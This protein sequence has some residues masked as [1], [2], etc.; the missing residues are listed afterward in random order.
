MKKFTIITILTIIL[1]S[2]TVEKIRIACVGDS[3]TEG[4]GI[5]F[6]NKYSYPAILNSLLGP[7]YRVLNSGKGG[8]TL[9]KQGDYSYWNAKEFSNVFAFNPDI[10]IIKLGTNDTK[11]QNWNSKRFEADYQALIDTLKS[12]P[13]APQIIMCI[14]VPVFATQWGINDSTLNAGVI[15]IIKQIAEKNKIQLVDLN[16]PLKNKH[17]LFPDDIHPN[18]KGTKE[19]AEIIANFLN[20]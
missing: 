6:Q 14:P 4:A 5:T 18:E 9:Q 20:Q 17:E 1:M 3:I 10:V 13:K 8:T 11:P 12:M 2:C 7:E 16:T 15:P 19:M